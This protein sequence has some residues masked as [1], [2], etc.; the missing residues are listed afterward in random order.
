MRIVPKTLS[1]ELTFVEVCHL[2]D[3]L[4]NTKPTL[5]DAA[6]PQA[7]TIAKLTHVLMTEVDHVQ[8]T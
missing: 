6:T 5:A 4:A 7:K 3:Y 1:V 8:G 2:A